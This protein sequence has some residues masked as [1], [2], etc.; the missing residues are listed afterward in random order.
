MDRKGRLKAE[1]GDSLTAEGL[2]IAGGVVRSGRSTIG[3]SIQFAERQRDP[4]VRQQEHPDTA[5]L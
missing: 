1:F 2:Q 4:A 5:I 3:T